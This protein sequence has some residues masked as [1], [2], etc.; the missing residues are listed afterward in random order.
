MTTF[1]LQPPWTGLG[2]LQSEVSSIQSELRRKANDYEVST[3]SSTVA[4]L[5]REVGEISTICDELRTQLQAC[6]EELTALPS[7]RQ[8][9]EL[10]Q[11]G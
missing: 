9:Q 4:R 10:E 7:K 1:P 6:Q 8:E 11:D 2:S 3:I 5:E